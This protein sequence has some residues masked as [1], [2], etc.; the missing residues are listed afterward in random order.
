MNFFKSLSQ[1]ISDPNTKSVVSNIVLSFGVKGLSIF[2]TLFT[3]PAYI[4]YFNN[5]EVLGVWFTV[6]SVLT[7]VLNCDF[8]VGHG[9]RNKL[10]ELFTKNEEEK[11]KKYISSVYAFLAIVS[12][13]VITIISIFSKFIVDMTESV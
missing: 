1:K 3:T 8:G 2:V 10:A 4:R 9:L 13:F 7:W 12:A 6:L 5:D 11:A